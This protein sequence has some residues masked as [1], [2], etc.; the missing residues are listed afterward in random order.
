MIQVVYNL[1]EKNGKTM[2][3]NN[4]EKSH[5]IPL[6]SLVEIVTDDEN[7][8]LRLFVVKHSRDCDG[9]PLYDLS[10]EKEAQKELDEFNSQPKL[11]DI[12]QT[13]HMWTKGMLEAKFYRHCNRSML[14]II[15]FPKSD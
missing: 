9:E 8:G 14:E 7:N 11:Y 15:R 5:D 10:F 13:L 4:L 6:Y 3:E 1:V 12:P 2:R